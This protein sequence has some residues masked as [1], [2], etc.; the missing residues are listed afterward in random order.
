MRFVR[1]DD[2]TGKC[3]FLLTQ[4]GKPIKTQRTIFS[5]SFYTMA[6]SEMAIAT[7]EEKYK[8]SVF[9]AARPN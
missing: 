3:F 5:E 1:K 9:W 6:M 2:D 7:K 8:A 4:D